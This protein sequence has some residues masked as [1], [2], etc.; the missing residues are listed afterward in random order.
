LAA[1]KRGA[2][3]G[4]VAEVTL[5]DR[6]LPVSISDESETG[7]KPVPDGEEPYAPAP[8]TILL[9]SADKATDPKKDALGTLFDNQAIPELVETQITLAAV[10][11]YVVP[12]AD[13]AMEDQLPYVEPI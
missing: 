7:W 10:P 4:R 5:W 1:L 2:S 8:A 13:V 6:I 9:P 11:T 3:R 12:S